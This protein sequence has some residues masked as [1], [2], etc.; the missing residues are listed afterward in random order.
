MHFDTSKEFR[1]KKG[2]AYLSRE[3]RNYKDFLENLRE[4][5]REGKL[6]Q[7]SGMQLAIR[8]DEYRGSGHMISI[9]RCG[10]K[11]VLIDPLYEESIDLQ[12]DNTD[13]FKNQYKLLADTKSIMIRSMFWWS[14]PGDE[15]LSRGG[16]GG[17]SKEESRQEERKQKDMIPFEQQRGHFQR[18]R[19]KN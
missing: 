18:S 6:K 17:E 1:I 2:H 5:Y 8:E 4:M 19:P 7:L 13:F 16:R 10:D 3:T 9:G 11:L 12:D 15:D 14:W